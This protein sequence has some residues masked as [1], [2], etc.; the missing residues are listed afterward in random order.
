MLTVAP[1]VHFAYLSPYERKRV[2]ERAQVATRRLRSLLSECEELLHRY[3]HTKGEFV[4]FFEGDPVHGLLCCDEAS[5]FATRY[6]ESMAE[7]A[8]QA[9]QQ[10]ATL[11]LDVKGRCN[12]AASDAA[13]E[14]KMRELEAA[15]ERA[16]RGMEAHPLCGRDEESSCAIDGS[17]EAL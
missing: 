1:G 3:D 10:L 7:A 2:R 12:D 13:V 14:L 17:G 9:R 8:K 11:R 16:E 5:V 6:A 4:L 15:E